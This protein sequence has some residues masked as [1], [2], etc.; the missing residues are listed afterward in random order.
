M[1]NSTPI[2]TCLNSDCP[3]RTGGKCKYETTP[4]EPS[5]ELDDILL[6]YGEMYKGMTDLGADFKY[7]FEH[8]LAKAAIKSL[9]VERVVEELKQLASLEKDYYLESSTQPSQPGEFAASVFKAVPLSV[10]KARIAEL[11]KGL[12]E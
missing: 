6:V 10:I 1:T 5:S 2:V 12:L 4:I 3:E 8:K 11:Q 7:R 9:I